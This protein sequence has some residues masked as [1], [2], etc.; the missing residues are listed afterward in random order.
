[1]EEDRKEKELKRKPGRPGKTEGRVGRERSVSV[2]SVRRMDEYVKRKEGEGEEEEGK[3]E[4]IFKRSRMTE[5]SPV[6]EEGVKKMFRE[7]MEEMREMRREL[8]EQKEGLSEELKKLKEVMKER[9]E[10]WKREREGL[11]KEIE[12]IK[13]KMKGIGKIGGERK[14]GEEGKKG[15]RGIKIVGEALEGKIKDLERWRE[16]EERERRRR[17][18]VVK[19]L[20]VKVER[21]EG[22]VRR[23]WKELG[24]GA[25]IE[26]IKEI[27]R[28]NGRER[29]MAI[30]RM[31]DREG[32]LEVMRR[33]VGLRGGMVRIGD[34]DKRR[35]S[36]AMEAGGLVETWVIKEEWERWKG[37]VPGEFDWMIQGAEKEGRRG[38]AKGGLVETWVIKEEWERWKG[39]VPGEFDWTIQGAEKE[40]RRGRAKGGI[41]MGIRR[42]LEGRKGG[43]EEKGIMIKEIKWGGE[44]WKVGTV[45]RSLPCSVGCIRQP[46]AFRR[47]TDDPVQSTGAPVLDRLQPTPGLSSFQSRNPNS[48]S[49]GSWTSSRS[50]GSWMIAVFTA[51]GQAP[52]L[53]HWRTATS[54]TPGRQPFP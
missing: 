14:E 29:R 5:R 45:V 24:V 37:R 40:G 44:K 47:P 27:G 28:G 23:I 50:Y 35:E 13:R 7:L 30:V 11:R 25:R 42:G 32:K 15:G 6:R 9:E 12:E 38:R 4:D 41:W 17:N 21:I 49:H 46:E 53:Q 34:D 1:M 48:R 16:L 22:E 52:Y 18:V 19:G 8:M 39:R 36:D 31:E 10:E 54:A 2:S 3:E 51:P 43:V 26:E 33:K 20:E